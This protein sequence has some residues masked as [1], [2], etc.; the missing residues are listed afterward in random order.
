MQAPAVWYRRTPDTGLHGPAPWTL[1]MTGRTPCNAGGTAVVQPVARQHVR[2]PTVHRTGRAGSN[3]IVGFAVAIG[4][5]RQLQSRRSP[6]RSTEVNR[7]G[8]P[9]HTPLAGECR[10]DLVVHDRAPPG[11]LSRNRRIVYLP[12]QSLVEGRIL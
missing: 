4:V 1:P 11:L 6:R 5:Y 10:R 2:R 12:S 8:R 9:H 3:L 7:A